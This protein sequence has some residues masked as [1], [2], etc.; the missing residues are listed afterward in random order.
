MPGRVATLAT[1]SRLW[2]DWMAGSISLELKISPRVRILPSRGISQRYSS[3]CFSL[4]INLNA[5]ER[6][7]VSSS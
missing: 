4:I 7:E 5:C 3:I 1:C 6:K 2:S